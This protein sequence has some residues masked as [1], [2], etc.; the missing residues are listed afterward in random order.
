MQ[1][2]GADAVLDRAAQAEICILEVELA[3][4]DFGEVEDVVDELQER[5]GR[6]LD[7]IEVFA[8]MWLEGGIE[9]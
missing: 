9:C 7:D 6:A 5:I 4:L 3:G 1:R 2:Q 8:L